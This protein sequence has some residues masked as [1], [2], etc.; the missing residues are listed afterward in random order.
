M[1]FV[2][3][4]HAGNKERPQMTTSKTIDPDAQH[5]S[6]ALWFERAG[7]YLKLYLEALEESEQLNIEEYL[8]Q[9]CRFAQEGRRAERLGRL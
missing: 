1:V 2:R 3:I 5:D 6:A 9:A 8:K 7:R 4:V